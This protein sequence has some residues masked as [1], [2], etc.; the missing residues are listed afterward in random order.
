MP[1]PRR[2]DSRRATFWV[3]ALAALLSALPAQAQVHSRRAD[4]A[5]FVGG[6]RSANWILAERF[7][8]YNVSDMVHSLTVNPRWIEGSDKF[9][10]EWEN[11]DGKRFWI[12]DPVRGTKREIFD[13]DVLA[14]ELTRITR[15]PWDG[16]H[17]PI[18]NIRFISDDVLHFSVTGYRTPLSASFSHQ[19][20]T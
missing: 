12:V 7:A 20:S 4:E 16:L 9:W 18:Q 17:L 8:P 19:S 5:G 1:S 11:S 2:S 14:A 15:D 3:I 10:Y 13:R 6:P